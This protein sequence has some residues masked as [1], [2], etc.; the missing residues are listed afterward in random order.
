MTKIVHWSSCKSTHHSGQ[1]VKK[2]YFSIDFRKMLKYKI[3]W[4]FFQWERSCSMRTDGRKDKA[5]RDMMKLILA[6]RNFQEAPKTTL[7]FFDTWLRGLRA[8]LDV[9]TE[10]KKILTSTGNPTPLIWTLL[11]CSNIS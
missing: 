9:V 10:K 4:K 11:L 6:S 2:L 8:D 3:S 7:S 5:G 1:N